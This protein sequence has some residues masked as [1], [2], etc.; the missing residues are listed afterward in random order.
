MSDGIKK[1]KTPTL[2]LSNKQFEKL[3][4]VCLLIGIIVVG[5]FVIYYIL[6]PEEKFG[7]AS[8]EKILSTRIG[9]IN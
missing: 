9:Y 6:T 3:L 7:T 4:T 2:D 8:N 1:K 5:V